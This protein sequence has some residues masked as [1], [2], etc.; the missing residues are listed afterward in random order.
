MVD[1]GD[2]D[3]DNECQGNSK[4]GT[5]NCQKVLALDPE[6]DCCVELK[7]ECVNFGDFWGFIPI[8]PHFLGMGKGIKMGMRINSK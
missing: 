4:C 2:C 6:V 7:D 3:L 8:K 5:N 1:E